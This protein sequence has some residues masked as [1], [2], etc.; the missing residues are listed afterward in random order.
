MNWKLLLSY[1]CQFIK[2]NTRIL[3][4]IWHFPKEMNAELLL[5]LNKSIGMINSPCSHMDTVSCWYSGLREIHTEDDRHWGL[6]CSIQRECLLAWVRPWVLTI[7][8]KYDY[9]DINILYYNLFSSRIIV[10]Q[11]MYHKFKHLSV[12]F[13]KFFISFYFIVLLLIN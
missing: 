6:R 13:D 5:L 4:Y 8:E 3:H 10:L 7:T 12:Q 1:F 11:F 9:E 2:Y